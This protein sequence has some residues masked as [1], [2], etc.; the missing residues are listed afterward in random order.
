MPRISACLYQAETVT[1][2]VPGLRFQSTPDISKALQLEAI[3]G[4][5]MIHYDASGNA[6]LH[7]K[8]NRKAGTLHQ[9]HKTT[10]NKSEQLDSIPRY[11][12]VVM[13]TL[14]GYMPKQDMHNPEQPQ[15]QPTGTSLCKT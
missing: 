15:I 14:Q 10:L 6:S 8:L 5:L 3:L 2:G 13:I 1:L 4:C 9:N 7:D 11:T 12:I